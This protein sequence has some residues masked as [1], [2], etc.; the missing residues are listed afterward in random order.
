LGLDSHAARLRIHALSF[1]WIVS[2]TAVSPNVGYRRFGAMAMVWLAAA[3]L[4]GQYVAVLPFGF[5]VI[6]V[7][8]LAVP[9]AIS[10]AYSSAVNKTRMMSYYKTSGWFY[11]LFQAASFDLACGSSGRSQVRS[12]CSCNFPHIRDWNG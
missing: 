8:I 12:L 1:V 11:K 10:G 3:Y 2:S 4:A 9:I 7:F 6:S 5:V